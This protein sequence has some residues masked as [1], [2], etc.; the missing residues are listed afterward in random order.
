MEDTTFNEQ[1]NGKLG[2]IKKGCGQY[3]ST[4]PLFR[5]LK[6]K[7]SLYFHNPERLQDEITEFYNRATNEHGKKTIADMWQ[8]LKSLYNMV[9]DAINNNY[10][11]LPKAKV[12]VGIAVILYV[13][14]PA[15]LIPDVLPV[16]GFVDDVALLA[17]F[18]KHAAK[19]IHQY[20]I[21]KVSQISPLENYAG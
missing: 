6:A 18:F 10:M 14:L 20:E 1:T 16:F 8:K 4:T 5:I 17:W 13:L 19:E 9:L 21:W 15:D 7:A 12:A 3:I 2:K 11:F